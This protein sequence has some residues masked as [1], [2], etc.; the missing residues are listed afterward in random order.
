MVKYRSALAVKTT[1]TPSSTSMK[2]F[3][4]AEANTHIF[5]SKL[6]FALWFLS[7]AFFSKCHSN[8]DFAK[9]IFHR[10]LLLPF[11]FYNTAKHCLPKASHTVVLYSFFAVQRASYF[12]II[13]SGIVWLSFLYPI[14]K[15]DSIIGLILFEIKSSAHRNTVFPMHDILHE[16]IAK[17]P[18]LLFISSVFL[19]WLEKSGHK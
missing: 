11:S 2:Y 17:K 6:T 14:Y 18:E 3:E 19:L 5:F 1:T 9:T 10:V 15:L 13:F 16:R 4:T 12:Y 8:N 7:K